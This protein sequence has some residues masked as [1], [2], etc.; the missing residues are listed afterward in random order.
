MEPNI[1][2][3]KLWFFI[4]TLALNFPE[5]PTYTDIKNYEDFFENLKYIIPCDKC[6]LHYSQ[7]LNTNPIRNHLKDSNTLFIWTIDLHNEV[8]KSLDKKILSYEEVT[9]IYKNNYNNP[10]SYKNI[11]NKIF[12]TRNYIILSILIGCVIGYFYYRK[13]YKFRLIK[14]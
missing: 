7:R 3:P 13:K 8:N 5:T 6:K 9:N 11:K 10:Y 1:W 14:C 2:G 4:H 12:N